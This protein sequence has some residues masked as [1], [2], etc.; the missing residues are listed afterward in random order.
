MQRTRLMPVLKYLSIALWA[1]ILNITLP[2]YNALAESVIDK[3]KTR[4]YLI[5]GCKENS[6][7]FGFRDKK[8]TIVGFDADICRFI[9][10]KLGVNLKIIPVSSVMRVDA[11]RDNMIDLSAST[12]TQ[13]KFRDKIIDF[14]LPYFH[15]GQKLLVKKENGINSYLD[16][17]GKT[18]AVVG[19]TTSEKRIK[20]VQPNA[21]IIAFNTHKDCFNALK[22]G[23]VDAFTSDS[24]MLLGFKAQQ[25]KPQDYE[26]AGDFFSDEPYAL[27]LAQNDSV[28]RD[29]VNECLIEMW[30]SGEWFRIYNKW[31]GPGTQYEYPFEKLDFKMLTWPLE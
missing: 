22:K 9:A 12:L 6:P 16:L 24:I 7:P 31:F 10:D 26:I 30:G 2:K 11:V 17:E 19:G 21:R 13:T 29:F 23:E 14:S 4:G 3:I 1:I 20:D 28:W 25:S 27:G 18:I 8:G 15:D 5:A